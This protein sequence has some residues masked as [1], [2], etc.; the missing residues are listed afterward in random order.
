MTYYVKGKPFIKKQDA[1]DYCKKHGLSPTLIDH[2]P[3]K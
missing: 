2:R 1:L 3:L